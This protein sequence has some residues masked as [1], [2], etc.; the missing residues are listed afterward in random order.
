MIE[1]SQLLLE[2][3]VFEVRYVKGYMYLDNSGK[4]L[5]SILD[6]YPT[7]KDISM[8]LGEGIL[9]TMSN[10]DNIFLRFLHD[11][12]IVEI[13][14]P[15]KLEFYRELTNETINLISKQLE[16]TTFTR[17]GNRFFYVLPIKAIEEANEIFMAAELFKIPE[18]KLSIFGKTFKEPEVKF[19]SI[20]EDV[21]YIVRL[22]TTSRAFEVP[23][24]PL[25]IDSSKLIEIGILIDIDHFTLK[26][27]DLSILN[28]HDLIKT[29]EHRLSKMI[30]TLFRERKT[31]AK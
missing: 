23:P 26:P 6:K 13:R 1:F 15:D 19:V 18:E 25:K 8:S 24:K 30:P 16:I 22:S 14:Y 12:T 31:N 2:R 21:G 27:V 29:N 20:D 4:A 28:C 3:V 9:L 7:F 11:K 5:N 17:I 10:P